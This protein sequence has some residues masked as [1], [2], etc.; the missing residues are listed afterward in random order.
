MSDDSDKTA[1]AQRPRNHL[2]TMAAFAP[3]TTD[4][5]ISW[6]VLSAASQF[7]PDEL[8]KNAEDI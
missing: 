8:E 7:A 2:T 6:V 3:I 5:D 4:C 1:W